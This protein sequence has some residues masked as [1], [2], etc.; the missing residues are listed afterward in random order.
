MSYTLF[1]CYSFVLAAFYLGL[2]GHIVKIP[3]RPSMAH[4]YLDCIAVYR[5]RAIKGLLIFS[6]K[7]Y[8]KNRP[9]TLFFYF[10]RTLEVARSVRTEEIA[11]SIRGNI[12]ST[13]WHDLPFRSFLSSFF[14]RSGTETWGPYRGG[15]FNRTTSAAHFD[16]RLGRLQMH[17]SRFS[18]ERPNHLIPL[19]K[20]R[21][22]PLVSFLSL[23][24]F[25]KTRFGDFGS[26]DGTHREAR[27]TSQIVKLLRANI[28]TSESK[29]NALI[30]KARL[31]RQPFP[32]RK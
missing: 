13:K 3:W 19:I 4:D 31:R 18:N 9:S 32:G 8:E 20:R 10:F 17:S 6:R 30:R 21:T 22:L 11:N 29:R 24:L 12:R 1:S 2:S 5:W 25:W 16:F 23:F 27:T 14:F 7:N 15:A 28:D 26:A